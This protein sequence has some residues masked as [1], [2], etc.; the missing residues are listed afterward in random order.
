MFIWNDNVNEIP[1]YVILQTANSLSLLNC[2]TSN[3]QYVYLNEETIK[4]IKFAAYTCYH[5]NCFK[6]PF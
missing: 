6:T 5:C 4:K 2:Q 1:V 3:T